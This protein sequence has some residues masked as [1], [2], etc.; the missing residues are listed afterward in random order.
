MKVSQLNHLI[1][2]SIL[3][4]EFSRL[5]KSLF[6]TIICVER[7]PNTSIELKGMILAEDG[8]H[9][10]AMINALSVALADAGIEMFDFI[11]ACHLVCTHLQKH[12]K[13]CLF[14]VLLWDN[15]ILIQLRLK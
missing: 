2:S 12:L 11:T 15:L 14:R 5:V 6:E 8:S 13:N 4:K 7:Y 3:W 1:S 10:G 9:L